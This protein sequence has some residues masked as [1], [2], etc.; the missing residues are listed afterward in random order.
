MSLIEFN[1]HLR[2]QCPAGWRTVAFGDIVVRSQYGLS[3]AT[4]ST[5][6]VRMLGMSCLKDGK[7]FYDDLA[8]IKLSNEEFNKF[9]LRAGDILINR[10]N[11]IELVGKAS[12]VEHDQDV[13]FA[14]YVVRF[15]VDTKQVDPLYIVYYFT[16]E[17]SQKRLTALAT[18]GVSQANI[19]PEVLKKLFLLH[20]PSLPEQQKIAVILKTWNEA[21]GLTEQLIE[22][23]QRYKKALMKHL[24]TGTLRFSEFVE[25]QWEKVQIS[26]IGNVIAGGTPNT[27]KSE[28][29]NGKVYWVTP[30]E[31]T[32]LKTRYLCSTER[33]ITCLG[34]KN[35]SA[36]LLPIGSVVVCT[37]A[38]VGDCAI[39]TVPMATNQGF[40]SIIPTKEYDAEFIYYL[41]CFY[42]HEFI[43]R[44]CGST[45]LEISKHDFCKLRFSFPKLKEQK[46]I[47]MVLNKSTQEIENLQT[48]YINL[49]RQK[50][51]LMQQL[52]TG[53]LKVTRK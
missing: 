24:L 51:G 44:A 13:V 7:I 53:K 3:A 23:K 39:T 26:D 8:L 41:F 34:L 38:T 40:K 25:E 22:K 2:R 52:L 5:G 37:R 6:N 27:N 10:T 36:K 21:I 45:F 47:A 19:N 4:S 12:L 18:R 9:R 15:L 28:Y 1:K 31:I 50:S 30:T 33:R 20:L 43:R 48:R 42:K 11:S 16:K 14:S 29:W 35:S 32:S 46:K 49:Q 17:D